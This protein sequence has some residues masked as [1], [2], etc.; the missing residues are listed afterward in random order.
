MTDKYIILLKR[1]LDELEKIGTNSIT[2]RERSFG[3]DAWK[4]STISILERIFGKESRKIQEVERIK[5][6]HSF[7]LDSSPTYYIETVKETAKAII[8]SC[9]SELEILGSPMQIYDGNNSGLNLTVVQSQ[10][11]KQTIK[12]DLIVQALQEELTGKELSEIQSILDSKETSESKKTKTIDKLKT[13][14]SDTLSNIIA[15]ILTN[16]SIWGG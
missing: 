14:G 6:G 9:I 7:S 4:S 3:V 2:K 11:N 15:G 13:F 5:L 1:Q 8:E 16:P 12:L 10:S